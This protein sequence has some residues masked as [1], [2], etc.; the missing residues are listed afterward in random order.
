MA[1]RQYEAEVQLPRGVPEAVKL[2]AGRGPNLLGNAVKRCCAHGGTW[3]KSGGRGGLSS[4]SLGGSLRLSRPATA[5]NGCVHVGGEACTG[6]MALL[7]QEFVL[8]M[9]SWRP[10]GV[11]VVVPPGVVGV[12]L[13]AAHLVGLRGLSPTV[14]I[15]IEQTLASAGAATMGSPRSVGD[16]VV[17][18]E[19]IPPWPA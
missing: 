15:E 7:R 4:P 8:T 6:D 18:W 9:M 10:H 1:V 14:D 3:E 11:G 13:V 5:P 19:S 17:I 16:N 12:I 2:V